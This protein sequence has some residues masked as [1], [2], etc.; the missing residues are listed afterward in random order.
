[1]QML[2][3]LSDTVFLFVCNL[4]TRYPFSSSQAMY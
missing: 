3:I 4:F 1:M 2:N